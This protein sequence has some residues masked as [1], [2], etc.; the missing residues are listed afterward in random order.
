[1]RIVENVTGPQG[2][3][4]ILLKLYSLLGVSDLKGAVMSVLTRL[5]LPS[6][7]LHSPTL[8]CGGGGRFSG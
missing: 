5:I 4:E 6:P 1:M 3:N 7:T 2:V 8:K